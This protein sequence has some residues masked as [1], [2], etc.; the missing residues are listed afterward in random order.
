MEQAESMAGYL[1]H[2]GFV[3]VYLLIFNGL[4]GVVSQ[5]TGLFLTIAVITSNPILF[6]LLTRRY[7]EIHCLTLQI[8][9]RVGITANLY[10]QR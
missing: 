9:C 6:T 3:V 4:H 8:L 2:A 10:E 1:F 5:K 7:L